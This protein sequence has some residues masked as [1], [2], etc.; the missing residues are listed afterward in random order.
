MH[1]NRF[2]LGIRPRRRTPQIPKLYLRGPTS[3]GKE[4][5]REGKEKGKGRGR[6]SEG[7]GKG[8]EGKGVEGYTPPVANSL[9]RHC[10]GGM[11][12]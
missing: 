8:R 5:E 2:R 7:K 11:E 10:P 6:G 12:G 3:K 4:R 1:Q 9:L